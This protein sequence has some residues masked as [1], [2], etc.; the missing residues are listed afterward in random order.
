MTHASCKTTINMPA[1]AIWHV[2][3]DFAAA[4]HYLVMIKSGDYP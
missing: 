2:L 4:C 3:S 1:D